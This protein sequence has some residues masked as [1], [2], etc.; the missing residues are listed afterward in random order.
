M[1]RKGSHRRPKRY[2]GWISIKKVEFSL[3][4][5][6]AKLFEKAGIQEVK[7]YDENLPQPYIMAKLLGKHC[8]AK[9][10]TRSDG[11]TLVVIRMSGSAPI[12]GTPKGYFWRLH[13]RRR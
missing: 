12:C 3:L 8:D 2:K 13:S 9:V 5:Q 7:Y 11:G 10:Y 1:S 6:V 4:V